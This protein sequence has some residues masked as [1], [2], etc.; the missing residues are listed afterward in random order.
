MAILGLFKPKKKGGK[1]TADGGILNNLPM[2]VAREA[3]STFV[4]AVDL[5]SSNR[6]TSILRIQYWE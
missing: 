6:V 3:N 2:S 4:F 1:T 5:F